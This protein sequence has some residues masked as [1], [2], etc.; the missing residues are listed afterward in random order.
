MGFL[1]GSPMHALI[2]P[3]V[4]ALAASLVLLA[5]CQDKHEPLKPTVAA[6]ASAN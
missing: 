6:S 4:L 3:L 1:T 2:K 5:G